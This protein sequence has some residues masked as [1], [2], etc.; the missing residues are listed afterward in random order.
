MLLTV[1][2]PTYNRAHTLEKL[3]ESLTVQTDPHFEWI[4]VD[5]GSN[6]GTDELIRSFENRPHTFPI[7]YYTQNHGGKH[8]A[9]NKAID[10]AHG[11]WFIT[12]DSNKYLAPDAVEWIFKNAC[13]VEDNPKI[14]GIGGY[15]SDFSGK[16]IGG[17]IQFGGKPYL[18]CSTLERDTYNIT[19]D[20]STAFRTD[21]L[22]NYKSPEYENETFVTEGAWLLQQ[23]L[24]GYLIRWTP[25]TLVHGE[26]M[27]GGLTTQGANS[28]SGHEKN[29]LGYLKYVQLY[30]KGYGME[31]SSYLVTEAIEIARDKEMPLA[32]LACRLDCPRAVLSKIQRKKKLHAMIRKLSLP[33]DFI[34]KIGGDW[35]IQYLKR[36]IKF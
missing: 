14:C 10:L 1:F 28:R 11:D 36:K 9:Q 12:C 20:K 30:I 15:R 23:A 22:K 31:A 13:T 35:V 7:F 26:Y 21:N 29:F 27:A 32:E 24:D 25:H 19:G 2:T 18:D 8:R 34:R 16:H 33:T 3:F 17:E 6:D 5:D 4:I